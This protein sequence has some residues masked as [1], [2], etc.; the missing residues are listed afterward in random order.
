MR[1]LYV[2]WLNKNSTAVIKRLTHKNHSAYL[3]KRPLLLFVVAG[4]L[5]GRARH[6]GTDVMIF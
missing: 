3:S 6:P 5:E 4:I 1:A 2:L